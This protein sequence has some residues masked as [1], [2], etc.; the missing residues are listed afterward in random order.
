[1]PSL[2]VTLSRLEYVE[3]GLVL[4]LIDHVLRQQC[5]HGIGIACRKRVRQRSTDVSNLPCPRV[6][7]VRLAHHSAALRPDEVAVGIGPAVAES[8]IEFFN[9]MHNREV[10]EDLASLIEV[11]DVV[12][13]MAATSPLA[14]KTVV[15]TGTLA[16]MTRAEAKATAEALGAKVAGSVSAK[17]DYVIV[18]ADAGSKAKKAAGLGVTTLSEAEWQKLAGRA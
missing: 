1:M 2:I 6:G 5:L 15:F 4:G 9:E 16:H 17:T 14:G 11:E 12:A 3:G 10:L 8:L 18:G 7:I 13:D